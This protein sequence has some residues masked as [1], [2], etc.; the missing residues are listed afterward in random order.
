MATLERVCVS[1]ERALECCDNETS[2]V[3]VEAGK[4]LQA[5][6]DAL[7]L[8]DH[9]SWHRV[10]RRLRDLARKAPAPLTSD[11]LLLVPRALTLVLRGDLF[12]WVSLVSFAPG[13]PEYEALMNR[14][15]LFCCPGDRT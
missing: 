15:R 5:H 8:V 4:R 2:A 11:G 6:P 3:A 13:T 1:G 9:L 12:D 10:R 14:E 7:D